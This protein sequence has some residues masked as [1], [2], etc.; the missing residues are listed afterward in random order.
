[1]NLY[2]KT[3]FVK[4]TIYPP[5]VYYISG[6]VTL[7]GVAQAGATV[8]LIDETSDTLIGTVTTD[9]NGNYIFGAGYPIVISHTYH[10]AVEYQTGGIKY[11]ALSQPFIV[12]V[13]S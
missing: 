12:P 2:G 5:R 8:Y 4:G 6:N 1:M 11:N 7:G 13:E 10:V 9:S 3:Y